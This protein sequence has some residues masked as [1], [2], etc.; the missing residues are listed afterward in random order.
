MALLLASCGQGG[1]G[2]VPGD[3]SDESAYSGIAE[4]EVINLTGTEP[5]WN[6][7]IE[8]KTMLYRTP[9]NMDGLRVPVARFAGRGGLAFNG[10]LDGRDLDLAITPAQCSDGM[11]DR[12]YPYVA[13]LQIGR[14]LREGC[15]WLEGDDIGEPQAAPR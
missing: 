12:S 11:S 4:G 1:V 13:T 7:R 3:T 6:A 9:E 10:M 2:N 15:A 14:D 5:F 8:G